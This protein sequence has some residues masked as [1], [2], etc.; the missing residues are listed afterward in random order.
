MLEYFRKKDGPD[1]HFRPDSE[2]LQF[3]RRDQRQLVLVLEL[4]EIV[5]DISVIQ[6]SI[7]SI[8]SIT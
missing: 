7:P 5:F 8:Q 4:A 1:T 2:L 6:P 3:M